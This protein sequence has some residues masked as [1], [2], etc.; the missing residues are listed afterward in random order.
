[1]LKSYLKV[2]RILPFAY[3]VPIP[4]FFVTIPNA[5]GQYAVFAN[6]HSFRSLYE[7]ELKTPRPLIEFI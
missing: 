5:L 3:T 1:M 4:V 7:F 6:D 2:V